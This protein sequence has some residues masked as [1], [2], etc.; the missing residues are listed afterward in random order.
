MSRDN[1]ITLPTGNLSR[2]VR[3]SIHASVLNAM[4][5]AEEIW[6][7]GMSAADYCGLM[8]DIIEAASQRRE[9][10][11]KRVRSGELKGPAPDAPLA[12]LLDRAD[13]LA[14]LVETD[15]MALPAG[16]EDN[17]AMERAAELR[18]AMIP[19]GWGEAP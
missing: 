15:A 10:I 12:A 16:V 4:Q 17:P 6:S 13:M 14:R 19:F 5:N 3:Q 7:D 9:A 11:A 8:D 1:I 18:Q 2:I